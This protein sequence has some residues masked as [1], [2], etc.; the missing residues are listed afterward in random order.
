M[1][2]KSDQCWPNWANIGPIW[3]HLVFSS[4]KLAKLSQVWRSA[5]G[6]HF[7]N[8]PR[9]ILE[10]F[11]SISL[12]SFTW[13]VRSRSSC[14]AF[15]EHYFATPVVR[16]R[17]TCSAFVLHVSEGPDRGGV[18]GTGQKDRRKRC[19][20]RESALDE[21]SV[22]GHLD[23]SVLISDF[24]FLDD[25]RPLQVRTRTRSIAAIG[26]QR[27]RRRTTVAPSAITARSGGSDAGRPCVHAPLRG[28]GRSAADEVVP[29][30]Q[31]ALRARRRARLATTKSGSKIASNVGRIRLEFGRHG[32]EAGRILSNSA[33]TWVRLGQFRP[34]LARHPGRGPE[35]A[36]QYT[37]HAAKTTLRRAGRWTDAPTIFQELRRT[38][39]TEHFL[40]YM[41]VELGQHQAN[42]DQIWSTLANFD[43]HWPFSRTWQPTLDTDSETILRSIF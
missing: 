38:C 6:K 5:A 24:R 22:D 36:I 11:S 21:A 4:Q 32:A 35:A 20:S 37:K 12:A 17:S 16:R 1:R 18:G 13:F 33:P 43:K 30:H 10:P 7:K 19:S 26:A 41:F 14:R 34:R 25:S 42:F 15:V 8:A 31:A 2:L 40:G 39:S 3:A 9:I 23:L 27:V 29:G 28:I